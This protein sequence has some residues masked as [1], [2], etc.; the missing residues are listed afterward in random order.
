MR[1]PQLHVN[2]RCANAQFVLSTV[3]AGVYTYR[4]IIQV[5]LF[6]ASFERQIIY[7]THS[8]IKH[9]KSPSCASPLLWLI[10]YQQSPKAFR[11]LLL[12]EPAII[13]ILFGCFGR[14]ISPGLPGGLII[15][16]DHLFTLKGHL[17]LRCCRHVA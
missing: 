5:R 17:C 2:S 7:V 16:Q 3:Q 1:L 11:A 13:G 9:C 8:Q 12:D 4:I 6:L 15:Y 10:L 14:T